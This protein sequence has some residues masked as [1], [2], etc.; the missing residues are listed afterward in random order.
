DDMDNYR[1]I[2]EAL[3]SEFDVMD[4]AM[5]AV[6][7]AHEADATSSNEEIRDATPVRERPQG[8]QRGERSSRPRRDDESRGP[9]K[10]RRTADANTAR[11]FIGIGRS[12]GIRPQDLVGAIANE[13]GISG[14]DIGAIEIADDSSF[15]EV[16]DSAAAAVVAALRGTKIRG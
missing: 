4:I 5:A 11:I 12:A 13:A 7:I 8:R 10:P 15:V 14:R 16:P 1:V 2:V 9:R 3:A 6:K